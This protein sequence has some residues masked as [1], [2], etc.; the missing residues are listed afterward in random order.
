VVLA[1]FLE[2]LVN[3]CGEFAG[4]LEDQRARHAGPRAAFLKHGDHRQDES[5]GLAGAGLCD[6]QHIAP[7]ENVGDGLGLDGGGGFVTGRFDSAEDLVGQTKFR[8]GRGRCRADCCRA[9]CRAKFRRA[10]ETSKGE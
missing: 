3:L 7:R 10:H 9:D 1:V 4:R 5:G 2:A 6:P 8:E